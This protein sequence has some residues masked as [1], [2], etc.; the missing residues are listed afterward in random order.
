[1]VSLVKNP[2]VSFPLGTEHPTIQP[3]RRRCRFRWCEQ[4][5]GDSVKKDISGPPLGGTPLQKISWSSPVRYPSTDSG[6]PLD[7]YIHGVTHIGSPLLPSLDQ[8]LSPQAGD[9][10]SLDAASRS[11]PDRY[12]TVSPS[13]HWTTSPSHSPSPM[14][15]TVRL[16]LVKSESAYKEVD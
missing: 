5:G 6:I 7:L 2:F 4:F 9:V 15:S 14:V 10:N 8:L 12:S 16:F 3:R 13:N 1:V 11:R